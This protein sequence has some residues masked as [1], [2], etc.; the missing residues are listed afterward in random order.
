MAQQTR[1]VLAGLGP[2]LA[3]LTWT[4]DRVL[5]I[6]RQ[7]SLDVVL[8][9]F[10]VDRI[11]A[12][13]RLL[14]G[15]WVLR[16]LS[17]NPL[18]PTAVNREPVQGTDRV[19]ATQDVI[20]LGKLM[21]RVAEVETSDERS[22]VLASAGPSTAPGAE[23]QIR[24][25]G[26]HMCVQA[27]TSRSWDEAVEGAMRVRP[28]AS[29]P[30]PA[31]IAAPTAQANLRMA[32]GART[33]VR[34]NFHLM[35]IADLDELLQSILADFVTTMGAQRGAIIL[36]HPITGELT[37][38]AV[39]GPGLPPLKT[40]RPYSR[41]LIDR[42]FRVG[43]SML[44]RD[45]STDEDLL[46][47]RSVRAGTMSSIICA[48]L[49]SPRQRLGVLHLDRGPMQDPFN[50]D[51]LYLSDAIAASVAI[52]IESAQL[53][54]QQRQQFID[55]VQ[56]LA[57]AVEMRDQYTGEHTRRV[58]DYSLLLA[59]QLRLPIGDKY[60]LQIGTPLHDLGKIGIDDAILRKPGKLTPGE[61]EAMKTHTTKGAAMVTSLLNMAP[62]I[63]I[64]KHHH[65]RYDGKGYPDGLRGEQIPLSARIVA[66]ADAFDAMTS[67]RPYRKALSVDAAFF[68]LAKSAGTHFDPQCAHAFLQARAKV[69]ALLHGD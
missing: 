54:E 6:G 20:Q 59:E 66:V 43:E 2:S 32:E 17:R 68:E 64:I 44:C 40:G 8:R 55:T 26:L 4:T 23:H 12:E 48:L 9:D 28:A 58:T 10:S 3:G 52:G 45:A 11:H 42:C 49:R 22:P 30:L 46:Q 7:N 34:A 35:R 33:L 61:F 47:A 15:R 13:V 51:D 57:R 39:L 65:E 29:T 62:M 16:D 21:L 27:A 67:D 38:R 14:A 63:P 69:E 37:L 25:S 56:T 53:I 36:A 50:E 31:E 18:Y 5:R 24:A 19:L 60:Q 41:T 1:I